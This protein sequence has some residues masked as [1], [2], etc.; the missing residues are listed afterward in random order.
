[1]NASWRERLLDFLSLRGSN[2]VA[3]WQGAATQELVR[4]LSPVAWVDIVALNVLASSS[5][6]RD[7]EFFRANAFR[8]FEHERKPKPQETV[9]KIFGTPLYPETIV[10]RA[11]TRNPHMWV[12][13][14]LIKSY[15]IPANQFMVGFFRH[16]SSVGDR[17]AKNLPKEAKTTIQSLKYLLGISILRDVA[18]DPRWLFVSLPAQV[19]AGNALYKRASVWVRRMRETLKTKSAEVLRS[20]LD[21]GWL[22]STED[23]KLF[24]VFAL[25]VALERVFRFADWEGFEIASGAVIRGDFRATATA[26]GLEIEIRF[27]RSLGTKSSQYLKIISGY[28]A[29]IGRAR[30]P[31]LQLVVTRGTRVQ[32]CL[33]EVKHTEPDSDYSRD[34]VYKVLGY[35]KDCSVL[36]DSND[37]YPHAILLLGDNVNPKAPIGARIGEE[38]LVT[39]PALLD[40]DLDAVLAAILAT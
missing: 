25:G 21:S 7:V 31:D 22:Q 33:V 8:Y 13:S 1:V 30:R 9:G 14:R 34:S 40:A 23:E 10:A 18:E 3:L 37:C 6:A 4:H 28:Q 17:H 12:S 11:R 19:R 16:L 2:S 38:V 39:D 27:D 20:A 36:W 15:D 29:L 32:R 5:F 24:E 26:P 35:L